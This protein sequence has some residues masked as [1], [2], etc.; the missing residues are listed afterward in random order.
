MTAAGDLLERIR[1]VSD[2]CR[3]RAHYAVG[4][5]PRS[6]RYDADRQTF[7]GSL[8]AELK[9]EAGRRAR[10]VGKRTPGVKHVVR[11]T[12][13]VTQFRANPARTVATVL[14]RQP[15]AYAKSLVFT[16]VTFLLLLAI[17]WFGVLRPMLPE[18]AARGL[19][20]GPR[21]YGEL[22]E[23]DDY[24]P[25]S[26]RLPGAPWHGIVPGSYAGCPGAVVQPVDEQTRP[27]G[28]V[29]AVAWAAGDAVRRVASWEP[30]TESIRGVLHTTA[31]TAGQ[32]W[33]TFRG[34]L[35]GTTPEPTETVTAQPSAASR[36]TVTVVS[37][38]VTAG[39]LTDAQVAEL[40]LAVGWPREEVLSGRV[41]ARVWAESR[42]DPTAR[43][44]ADGTHH[45]LLQ[46]GTAEQVAHLE[47]GASAFDPRANLRAARRLW[48]SRGWEPWRASD[49]ASRG[50]L[51]TAALAAQQVTLPS[52]DVCAIP[53]SLQ[54]AGEP[55]PWGGHANGRIP[56]SELAPLGSTYLR[57]DAA[58]AFLA[59]SAAYQ[60]EFGRP[61][62]LTD[63]Y[64]DYAGQVSCRARKGNLCANPG[65][66]NHGWALAVDLGGGVQEFGTP[67]HEWMQANGPAYGFHH[68]TWAQ[69]GGSK[70]EPWHWEFGTP[71]AGTVSA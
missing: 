60:A 28:G 69:R 40:A 39:T 7:R 45:G 6:P 35:D 27:A 17:L 46:L 61:I 13:L 41:G 68:P 57:R 34:A 64:R 25:P 37:A 5:D 3:A 38:A 48:E 54:T 30:S 32:A 62:T 43:D 70:P 33:G 65:T 49:G 31:R 2:E 55:G 21:H 71:R 63:G 50:H 8:R 26:T 24:L 1:E 47:P 53:A 12:N 22:R 20:V 9:R 18:W 36:G 42:G 16:V 66:S 51:Q 67:Q 23:F 11:T 15:L 44:Y 59:M 10:D 4:T 58:T 14:I 52:A 29:Q 19:E 56:L